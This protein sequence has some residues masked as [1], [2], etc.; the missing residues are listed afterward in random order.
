MTTSTTISTR[1]GRRRLEAEL[2]ERMKAKDRGGM[3]RQLVED[4]PE[5]AAGARSAL[6]GL[7][8]R[9]IGRLTGLASAD[10]RGGRP[11]RWSAAERMTFDPGPDDE[12]LW[13]HQFTCGRSMQRTLDTLLKLR[14]EG[15][16]RNGRPGAGRTGVPAPTAAQR[17]HRP[18]R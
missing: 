1:S 11:G 8:E 17:S 3:A 14:R 10:E 18:G 7:V 6:L 4:M 13:R 2:S 12:R 9:T 5:D 15:R 16:A